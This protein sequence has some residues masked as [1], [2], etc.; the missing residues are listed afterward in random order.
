MLYDLDVIY[1]VPPPQTQLLQA[2]AWGNT[3]G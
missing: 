1:V 2:A 3:T